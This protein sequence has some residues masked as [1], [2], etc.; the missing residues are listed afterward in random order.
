MALSPMLW[1]VLLVAVAIVLALMVTRR[2]RRT[3][4]DAFSDDMPVSLT[5]DDNIAAFVED[6]V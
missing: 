6:T 1:I 3:G 5:A 2:R 4:G